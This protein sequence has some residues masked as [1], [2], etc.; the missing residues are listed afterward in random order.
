MSPFS[1][2]TVTT[3]I[4]QDDNGGAQIMAGVVGGATMNARCSECGGLIVGGAGW[5]YIVC[6]GSSPTHYRG[7]VMASGQASRRLYFFPRPPRHRFCHRVILRAIYLIG[8]GFLQ[9]D[10]KWM[11]GKL[12]L[13]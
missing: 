12:G 13:G 3:D 10:T 5:S 1:L 8:N 2:E 7:R 4:S 9:P 11:S 6:A